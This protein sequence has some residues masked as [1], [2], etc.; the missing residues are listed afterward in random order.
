MTIVTRGDLSSVAST[1]NG[2]E[3]PLVYKPVPRP[4][5]YITAA[6]AVLVGALIVQAFAQSPAMHWGT[7]ARY[8]FDP[9][10]LQG[11]GHTLLLTA[12]AMVVSTVVGVAL[13]MMGRSQDPTLRTVAWIYINLMRSIPLLVLI[14]F[15]YFIGLLVPRLGIGIP[16]V[17]PLFWSI[18]TNSIV[19]PFVASIV[20]LGFGQAAYTSEIVRG[21][22][23]A[24]ERGQAEAATALAMTP[25][26]AM[27]RVI[28]P[29][30][31][32]VIVPG[33]GNET[34]GMFKATSLVQVIGYT[35]LLTTAQRIYA[36][37]FETIPLLLVATAWYLVLTTLASVA[38][39]RLEKVMGRGY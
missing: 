38:Q 29:Q 30:A 1:G 11:L 6:L 3:Q 25:A 10:I 21:G 24:V 26:L 39:S 27:R 18:D 2:A 9:R 19:T 16:F 23:L 8:F 5:R 31:F 20:A 37:T 34:I 14:L 7:F 28:L 22:I 17:G 12:V 36:L 15:T 32:R 13:A 35:E 4:G 33:L